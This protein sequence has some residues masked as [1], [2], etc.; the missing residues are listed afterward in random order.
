MQAFYSNGS[1]S[2]VLFSVHFFFLVTH[3]SPISLSFRLFVCCVVLFI[4]IF[5]VRPFWTMKMD[6]RYGKLLLSG[7]PQGNS[8]LFKWSWYFRLFSPSS[9]FRHCHSLH[10]ISSEQIIIDAIE[11]LKGLADD[12]QYC[13]IIYI[14]CRRNK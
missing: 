5:F 10:L 9:L 14:M 3:F 12:F 13:V 6:V 11:N 2:R 7:H 4:Y 8:H 1:N